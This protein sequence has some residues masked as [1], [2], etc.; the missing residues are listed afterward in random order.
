MDLLVCKNLLDLWVSVAMYS[1]I[2]PG[3]HRSVPQTLCPLN[4]LGECC[5]RDIIDCNAPLGSSGW[6]SS[7]DATATSAWCEVKIRSAN[8]LWKSTLP[9]LHH[10]QFSIATRRPWQP[11]K[12]FVAARQT[13]SE[14]LTRFPGVRAADRQM[15]VAPPS[16]CKMR[17]L[18]I[19]CTA[20]TS[21][22]TLVLRSRAVAQGQTPKER[23][24]ENHTR[25]IGLVFSGFSCS[26]WHMQQH[27]PY[28][29]NLCAAHGKFISRGRGM[30]G[31]FT[32]AFY[33]TSPYQRL[34]LRSLGHMNAVK[35][36]EDSSLAKKSPLSPLT[37]SLLRTPTPACNATSDPLNT[38]A[39]TS[40]L[41]FLGMA[42][43]GRRTARS[44]SQQKMI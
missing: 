4:G 24:V 9:R 1:R 33:Q 31:P 18:I 13:P 7:F 3:M 37:S 34:K 8:L 44:E 25:P 22:D 23:S 20:V 21:G 10:P 19:A 38:T 43:Q 40:R 26:S 32:P 6:C 35:T 14:M 27:S 12:Q 39:L 11:S 29:G 28:C 41:T 15:C 36:Y 16:R 17:A 42:G 2:A 5:K 30:C